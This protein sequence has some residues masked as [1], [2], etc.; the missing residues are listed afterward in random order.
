MTALDTDT[1]PARKSGL[2]IN[3]STLSTTLL[4][5]LIIGS[6]SFYQ[7][8]SKSWAIQGE[9]NGRVDATFAQIAITL[10]ALNSKLESGT[11]DRYTAEIAKKDNEILE[12]KVENKIKELKIEFLNKIEETHHE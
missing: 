6:F 10:D 1:E 8:S 9:V 3:Q 12:L 4:I 5:A 7:S 11:M 2:Q